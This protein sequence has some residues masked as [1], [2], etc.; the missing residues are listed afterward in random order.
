MSSIST[1]SK[2]SDT[3]VLATDQHSKPLNPE[4]NTQG[5][6]VKRQADAVPPPPFQITTIDEKL[7][8]GV[9][10]HIH[11]AFLKDLWDPQ[12]STK[13][14]AGRQ[15]ARSLASELAAGRSFFEKGKYGHANNQWQKA[16]DCFKNPD[17]LNTWYHET[18]IRLLF[19]LGRMVHTKHERVAQVLL[20][21]LKLCSENLPEND[22]RKALFSVIGELNIHHLRDLH[23]KAAKCQYNGLATRLDKR[24]QLLH[25][26]KLNR[27]LDSLWFDANADLSE[28]MTEISDLDR[29][30]GADNP[31]SIYFMLLE[32]YRHVAQN[33][34]D[35]PE[36]TSQKGG[37]RL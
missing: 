15:A 28:W 10:N 30:L 23:A 20:D 26:V 22:S 8:F 7:L 16:I 1:D 12:Q 5:I 24:H 27:A 11:E 6:L 13:H 33:H 19:E 36:K 25:E 2:I 21:N 31:Y 4:S 35:K 29:D 37:E 34:F 3:D 32:A 9:Y 18:P 14:N 17:L